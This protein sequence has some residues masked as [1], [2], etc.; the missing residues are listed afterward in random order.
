[1]EKNT[2]RAQLDTA[3]QSLPFLVLII[4]SVLLSLWALLI[5]RQ[6]LADA[7]R[8]REGE[9]PPVQPIRWSAG[10]IVVG[11]LCYFFFLALGS[12]ASA[13]GGEPAARRSAA[14]NAWASLFVLAAA[15]IRLY[16]LSLAGEG[17]AAGEDQPA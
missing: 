16:D 17:P 9:L 4:V 1:M 14:I 11:A 10:A 15:V 8:G 7:L 6:G 3:N 12:W 13:Q 2:L 5:Q